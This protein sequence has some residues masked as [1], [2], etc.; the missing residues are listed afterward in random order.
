[1]NVQ[2]GRK[3]LVIVTV[4]FEPELSLRCLR[5]RLRLI[6]PHWPPC[7]NAVGIIMGDVNISVSQQ[8][9]GS[10]C[11]TEPSLTVTRERPPCFIPFFH[12]SSRLL[13]LTALGGTP[14][15]IGIIRTLSWIDRIFINLPMS[16]V[17]D[18]HYHSHVFENLGSRSIPSDHAAVRI[19]LRKRTGDNR[20]NAFQVGC[21]NIPF[22]VLF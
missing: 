17:R 12:M 2:S 3:N 21:P 6:A 18:F 22:S 16:E 20:A 7:P 11:G 15:F 1:M 19:V 14:L 13:N 8:K 9:G 4:H 10:M 5:E